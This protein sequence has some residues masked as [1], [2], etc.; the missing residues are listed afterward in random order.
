[1]RRWFA[2]AAAL[3]VVAAMITAAVAASFIARVDA[4]ADTAALNDVLR[5]AARDWPDLSASAFDDD[6]TITGLDGEVL[7]TTMAGPL[8]DPLEAA[9]RGIVSAPLVVDD[10]VVAT[11]HYRDDRG[12]ALAAAR[13]R[14]VWA[15]VGGV[16][17]IVLAVAAVLAATYLRI[18]RPFHRLQRFATDVAAGDLDAPLAMDR[19]NAFGAWSES[20]DLMR[21]EL[22]AARSR[23]RAAIESKRAL[24]SQISHDVRTPIA[25]IAAT[26]ELMHTRN[27]DPA[28]RAQLEVIRNKAQQI[29]TLIHDLN[30]A[31]ETRLAALPVAPTELASTEIARLIADADFEHLVA[32]F[33][34]PECL[35]VADAQRLAQ[36]VDNVITNSYKYART[37]IAVEAELA[38]GFLELRIGDDGPGVPE[39]ELDSIFG[40][41]VRAS[42][43]GEAPGHGLGLYT[44]AYLMERM[45]GA[46]SAR[47]RPDRFTVTISIPIA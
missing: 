22:A 38:D 16:S 47:N 44:S 12:S 28:A 6:V 26:A 23:E 13:E 33:D 36:V 40:R 32:P 18:I 15:V 2:G 29:D 9:R 21:S 35:I 11:V 25:S 7:V 31:N 1:M 45:D 4:A 30:R 24:V 42:N 3:I 39:H 19:A 5:T 34:I 20:F 41:G 17:G 14:A 37:A 46:I 43:A 27:A 8:P 10:R